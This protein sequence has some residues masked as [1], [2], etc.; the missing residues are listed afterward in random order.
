MAKITIPANQ[1]CLA[2]EFIRVHI[3][4]RVTAFDVYLLSSKNTSTA[5]YD[6]IF[7]TSEYDRRRH[8][9]AGIQDDLQQLVHELSF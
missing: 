8:G 9:F 4:G 2:G 6:E 1:H 3:E 5:L 7:D